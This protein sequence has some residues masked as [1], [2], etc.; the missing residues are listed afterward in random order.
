MNLDVELQKC[1]S[2]MDDNWGIQDNKTDKLTN[3][4]Y[5]CNT[6]D[7]V[8]NYAKYYKVDINYA[9]HRW[10]N[11]KTSIQVE[12][13]FCKYGA[14]KET[15][16]YNHDI[17]IYINTIPFDVKL[18]VYPKQ[19]PHTLDLYKREDKDRLINWFYNNQS[20]E[21][22]KQI[23]NRL[24]VVVDGKNNMALKSNKSLIEPRI[25]NYMHFTNTYGLYTLFI[26]LDGKFYKICSD[27]VYVKE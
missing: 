14:I 4:I 12:Q 18:T 22:R 9:L 13:I 2:L 8:I 26:K 20:Q 23:V 21:S 3:F 6:I 15:N 24:Y 16:K 17:D 27:L 25:A 1:L 19:L 5:K 7:E 10:Y 11:F